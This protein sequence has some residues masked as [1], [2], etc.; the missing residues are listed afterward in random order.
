MGIF[1]VILDM[2]SFC[3]YFACFAHSADVYGGDFKKAR[4]FDFPDSFRVG[5][6]II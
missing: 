1:P 4:T 5:F 6:I 3:Y 2:V